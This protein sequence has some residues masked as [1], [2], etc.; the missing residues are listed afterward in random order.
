MYIFLFICLFS[1]WNL[2]CHT[3]FSSSERFYWQGMK[4]PS[5]HPTIF[6]ASMSPCLP[7]ICSINTSHCFPNQ[8]PTHFNTQH[9]MAVV[10]SYWRLFSIKHNFTI[11]FFFSHFFSPQR[12]TN[13]LYCFAW[14]WD[15]LWSVHYYGLPMC[16]ILLCEKRFLGTWKSC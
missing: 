14:P 8:V 16:A 10:S 6:M 11:F 4:I 3:I 12:G 15:R 1:S 9:S 2:V 13:L 7:I 5:S